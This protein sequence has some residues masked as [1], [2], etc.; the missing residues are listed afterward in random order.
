MGSG[1]TVF[2]GLYRIAGMTLVPKGTRSGIDDDDVTQGDDAGRWDL[3]L[4]GRLAGYIDRLVIDWGPGDR[5]WCQRAHSKN[6][7][8]IGLRDGAELPFP[9]FDEFACRVA[10]LALI[11]ARWRDVLKHTKGVYLLLDTDTG[12]QYVGS[13]KGGD[14]LYGRWT[15]YASNAHGGNLGL[16]GARKRSLQVSVLATVNSLTTDAAVERL[17]SA[18]KDKLGS[19][20]FGLNRN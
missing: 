12:E 10:D 17:E 13:A 5:A 19:R 3:R 14:N 16:K 20:E 18:W 11:P 8:V 9:G 2:V 4:T 6:K 1:E 15:A 7:P